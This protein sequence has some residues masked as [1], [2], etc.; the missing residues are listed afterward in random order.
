MSGDNLN[1]F[2]LDLSKFQELTAE[3]LRRVQK[4]V[5]FDGLWKVTQKT[6]VDTGRARANWTLAA[7]EP[8]ETILP[9]GHYAQPNAPGSLENLG[10]FGM[11]WL[12]NQLPYAPELEDGS[13]K[14]APAGMVKVSVVELQQEIA[15][16]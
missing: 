6:P 12:N 10:L 14:Q 9:E 4:K 16:L 11:V 15:A 1:D 8:D 5:A 13:S 7:E 3:E 2:V